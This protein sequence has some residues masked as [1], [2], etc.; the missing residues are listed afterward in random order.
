MCKII[1]DGRLTLCVC[2]CVCVRVLCVHRQTLLCYQYIND[3]A[4]QKCRW[5]EVQTQQKTDKQ[6]S[7]KTD[8]KAM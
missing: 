1:Q 3:T 4:E 6:K 5:G 8:I 7:V 2:V